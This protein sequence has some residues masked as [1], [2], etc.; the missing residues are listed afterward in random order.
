MALSTYFLAQ[1]TMSARAFHI[2]LYQSVVRPSVCSHLCVCSQD[3]FQN[4]SHA[5]LSWLL[6][7]CTHVSSTSWT[8]RLVLYL[9]IGQNWNFWRIFEILEKMVW[10]YNFEM[11]IFLQFSSDRFV[12]LQGASMRHN[13][14]GYCSVKR[15]DQF[16]IFGYFFKFFFFFLQKWYDM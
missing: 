12:I 11:Y 8:T 14:Y 13:N 10:L 15:S 3:F 9:T 7:N 16:W 5:V 4:V 6:A 1:L 2:T